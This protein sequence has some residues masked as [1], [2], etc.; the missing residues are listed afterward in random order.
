MIAQAARHVDDLPFFSHIVDRI[1][2]RRGSLLA[3]GKQHVTLELD[4]RGLAPRQIGV[5]RNA[6]VACPACGSRIQPF[7]TR[8]GRRA[9]RIPDSVG[10]MFIS[11]SCR[12][13][14]S[15]GCA[16]GKAASTEVQ[17]LVQVIEQRQQQRRTPPANV[18]AVTQAPMQE[19]A[20]LTFRG[21]P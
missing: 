21:V 17:R 8:R 2:V 20:Q 4:T 3:T 14:D 1:D 7:R 10:R 13:E 16:R 15:P 11:G 18:P 5:L 19:S 12:Y 9:D 6:T